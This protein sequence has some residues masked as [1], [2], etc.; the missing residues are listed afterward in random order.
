MMKFNWL[1]FLFLLSFST[2]IFAISIEGNAPCFQNETITLEMAIDFVS[3]ERKV[4]ARCTADENGAFLLENK[5]INSSESRV[6]YIRTGRYE[7]VFYGKCNG[8]YTVNIADNDS[9]TAIRYDKIE[10]PVVLISGSDSLHNSVIRYFQRY[11]AFL[12]AH[13]YDY[14]LEEF[15]GSEAQRIHMIKRNKSMPDLFPTDLNNR[16][17]IT[18]NNFK[19][20]VRNFRDTVLSAKENQEPFLSQFRDYDLAKIE[21]AIGKSKDQCIEDLFNSKNISIHHPAYVQFAEMIFS[22]LFTESNRDHFLSAQKALQTGKL[23]SIENH[24]SRFPNIKSTPQRQMAYCIALRDMLALNQ[25]PTTLHD[26]ILQQ[27]ADQSDYPEIKNCATHL[28]QLAHQCKKNTLATDFIALDLRGKNHHAK[29]W[30]GKLT[31]ILF[32]ATWN[33]YSMKQLQAAE[34]IANSLSGDYNIVTI[35]MD[36]KEDTWRA[37][38]KGKKW[39]CQMLYAGN[40]PEL[41]EIYCIISLPHALLISPDGKYI[42]DYTKLPEAGVGVQIEKWLLSHP[43]NKGKG[44]WKEY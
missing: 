6:F 4:L 3:M 28:I 12:N 21:I 44:T 32:Y 34:N 22:A 18:T 38:L 39:K 33:G 30:E 1:V 11:E 2:P 20:L 10:F 36:D 7:G 41:R 5:N 16:D 25:I 19:L 42:Q 24:F 29:D 27:L 14:A 17:S 31:Y 23:D 15:S 8:Q 26:A 37:A 35:C 9:E 43:D 13:Y 40:I